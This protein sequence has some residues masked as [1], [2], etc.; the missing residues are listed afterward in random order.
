MVQPKQ[1]DAVVIFGLT[2]APQ[3]NEKVGVIVE[4]APTP[5]GRWVVRVLEDPPTLLAVKVSNLKKHQTRQ[6]VVQAL[7]QANQTLGDEA[8]AGKWS[9][10]DGETHSATR[11]ATRLALCPTDWIALDE[12]T[13]KLSLEDV[14]TLSVKLLRCAG[15]LTGDSVKLVEVSPGFKAT[16]L[17]SDVKNRAI[18]SSN[19]LRIGPPA[20]D[21][22]KRERL[23]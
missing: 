23:G 7:E 17:E 19:L 1:G 10:Q 9:L 2:G 8:A 20:T 18:Q 3:H 5:A 11:S 12:A 22:E 13:C 21:H 14:S 6:T 16:H 4:D 15:D